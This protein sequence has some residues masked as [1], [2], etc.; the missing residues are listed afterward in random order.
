[1]GKRANLLL[2]GVDDQTHVVSDTWVDQ[3]LR[4]V[5][6]GG[7]WFWIPLHCCFI[8][9]DVADLNTTQPKN[10][11]EKQNGNDHLKS[12]KYKKAKC[13]YL[14]QVPKQC[15][16]IAILNH[17]NQCHDCVCKG[18]TKQQQHWDDKPN[19]VVVI[20]HAY[21]IINPGT[22]MVKSFDAPLAHWT[23]PTPGCANDIAIWTQSSAFGNF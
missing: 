5:F 3:A 4:I 16:W 6:R 14:E 21:A 13:R 12:N 19:E 8:S 9:K 18:D 11:S 17:F 22:V 23:V 10:W 2:V 7:C 1:M 15:V 20:V